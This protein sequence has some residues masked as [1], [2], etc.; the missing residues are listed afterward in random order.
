MR[1]LQLLALASACTGQ[2]RAQLP[3]GRSDADL[4]VRAAVANRVNV[5]LALYSTGWPQEVLPTAVRLDTLMVEG[6][7]TSFRATVSTIA[8]WDPYVVLVADTTVIVFGGFADGAL[9]E[10]ATLL[11][12][13]GTHTSASIAQQL[14][15]TVESRFGSPQIV[16]DLSS[17]YT[18]PDSEVAR[19]TQNGPPGWPAS[20]SRKLAGGRVVV[21]VTSLRP[22][23]VASG[24]WFT[25]VSYAFL[26]A[27]DGR[28]LAAARRVGDPM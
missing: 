25:P 26:F 28:L 27:S 18:P 15:A 23:V 8:H 21:R 3:S 24:Q 1:L 4:S 12:A 7:V 20:G 6:Q 17:R 16:N 10:A 19:W 22:R 9:V 13:S 14:A 11:Q 2:L 5:E